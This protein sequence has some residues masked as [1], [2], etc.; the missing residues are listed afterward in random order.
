MAV[1]L[2]AIFFSLDHMCLIIDIVIF[3]LTIAGAVVVLR[4][5]LKGKGV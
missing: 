5:R 4:S 2:Y 1:T 3:V